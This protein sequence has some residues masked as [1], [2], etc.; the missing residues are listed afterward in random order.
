MCSG[1]S[2]LQ[3]TC[4]CN[5]T[6]DGQ[7]AD[8]SHKAYIEHVEFLGHKPSHDSCTVSS[9]ASIEYKY[10]LKCKP[11]R[12]TEGA[13]SDTMLM[14]LIFL[15]VILLLVASFSIWQIKKKYVPRIKELE[16]ER[17]RLLARN[18]ADNN[19]LAQAQIN[20]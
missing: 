20:E 18:D 2:V 17:N 12:G 4:C 14:M 5:L 13:Q 7:P 9:E 11:Q 6:T 19:T 15:C 8:G 10:V 16:N 3:H 1:C